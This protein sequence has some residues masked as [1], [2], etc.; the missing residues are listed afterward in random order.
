MRKPAEVAARLRRP[1]PSAAAARRPGAPVSSGRGAFVGSAAGAVGIAAHALGGGAVS[2]GDSSVALLLG[3]CALIGVVVNGFHRARPGRS[4]AGEL[5]LLLIAGQAVG[6]TALTLAPGH[7]HTSHSNN[8]M[9][10]AHALAVPVGALLIRAAEIG[11]ARAASSV[12]HAVRT[13]RTR[14]VASH[15]PSAI[16]T[17]VRPTR[18]ARRL[19]LCSG[20]G[21][22]GPPA[23]A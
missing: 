7:Q 8:L 6:H 20:I 10:L 22:R 15:A 19:L 16:V 13:L 9:L 17:A 3:A 21:T 18:T 2:L 4:G 5:A 14:P 23:Y 12:R 1:T 11:L